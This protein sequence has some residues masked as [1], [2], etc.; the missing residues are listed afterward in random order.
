MDETPHS[1]A[2]SDK[3]LVLSARDGDRDAF[4]CLVERYWQT[5]VAIALIKVRSMAQAEDVAQESFIT[6]YSRIT[7]LRNPERFAGWL[8]RIV[9]QRSIDSLRKSA[10]EAKVRADAGDE[11]LSRVQWQPSSNPGLTAEE[12][13]AVREAVRRLPDKLQ[14]VV[15]MRFVTG[16]SAGEIA[17][18]LGLRQG[19]ARVWLHRAARRLEKDLAP[20]ALEVEQ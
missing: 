2:P 9:A 15:I 4:G 12:A 7:D 19:T 3:D 1:S 5:A 6:A 13:G 11:L 18:K 8:S 20:L 10:R 17:E 16:L 14:R